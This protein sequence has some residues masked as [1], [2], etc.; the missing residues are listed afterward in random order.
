MTRNLLRGASAA[1]IGVMLLVGVV[2]TQNKREEREAAVAKLCEA[3]KARESAGAGA[4]RGGI[5][6]G[7]AGRFG[8]RAPAAPVV[9]GQG[10][11]G[12][13]SSTSSSGT[14]EINLTPLALKTTPPGSVVDLTIKGKFPAGS[15]FI[16]DGDN[17]EVVKEKVSENSYDVSLRIAPLAGPSVIQTEVFLPVTCGQSGWVPVAI[18]GGKYAWDLTSSTNGWKVQLRSDGAGLALTPDGKF[19]ETY[20]AEFYR[21]SEA[22]PFQVRR[23]TLSPVGEGL[24]AFSVSDAASKPGET[25]VESLQATQD[26]IMKRMADP[27]V[28]DAEKEKLS[29]EF[30]AAL[31]KFGTQV[32][33]F[34]AQTNDLFTCRPGSLKWDGKTASGTLQCSMNAL[35]LTGTMKPVR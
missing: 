22:K 24:Y 6:G 18:V 11:G 34:V 8:V 19:E 33:T 31:E 25:G 10:G 9:V 16:F 17:V 30:S 27:T 7:L 2:R 21:N 28:S 12:G 35:N 20:T 3:D 14:K 26:R 4:G 5:A 23:A 15:R 32:N 29:A 1:G 13:S